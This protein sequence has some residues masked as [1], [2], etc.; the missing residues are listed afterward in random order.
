[1]IFG[2]IAGVYVD[3]LDRRLIL[4]VD[5]RR[6]RRRSSCCSL[7]VPTRRRLIICCSRRVISTLSHLL[8]PGRDRDDPRGRAAPAAAAGELAPHRHAAGVVLPG[9]CA[10][11]AARRQDL[12]PAGPARARGRAAT[13]SARC[14]AGRCPATTRASVGTQAEPRRL[15]EAGG[16]RQTDVRPAGRWRSLHPSTT[17]TSSGR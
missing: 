4:V 12:E 17:A 2:A 6:T 13:S 15:G 8:R 14:C 16:A 5:Q 7:L 3:R 1:M 11:R 9:L 10:A